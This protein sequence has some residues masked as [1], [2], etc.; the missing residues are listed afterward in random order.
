MPFIGERSIIRPLSIV[1]RPADV[2]A[3]AAHRHLEAERAGQLHGIDDV[4][5]AVTAG[6][7]GRTLV[8]QPVVHTAAVVV[9]V[10]GRL[11]QLAGERWSDAGNGFGD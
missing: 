10:V 3:A 11:Q 9:G 1:A 2:V 4:G 5:D 6:D 7:G 8:D